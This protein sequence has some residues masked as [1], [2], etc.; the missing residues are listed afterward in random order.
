MLAPP[1]CDAV[2]KLS[3]LAMLLGVL[4]ENNLKMPSGIAEAGRRMRMLG[5]DLYRRVPGSEPVRYR[6]DDPRLYSYEIQDGLTAEF[7]LSPPAAPMQPPTLSA[8]GVWGEPRVRWVG[9]GRRCVP[10]IE[11]Q[12]PL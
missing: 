4:N 5:I 7:E 12:D 8:P 10:W 6:G 2:N 9:P 1:V 3:V 11:F